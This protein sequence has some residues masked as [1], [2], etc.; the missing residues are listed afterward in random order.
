MPSSDDWIIAQPSDNCDEA[1]KQRGLVCSEQEL[2]KHNEEVDSCE[3]LKT[4]LKRLGD[5]EMQSC[6]VKNG[7]RKGAPALNTKKSIIF[8]SSIDRPLSS[9]NCKHSTRAE[10]KRRICFCHGS[11]ILL[12]LFK[13]LLK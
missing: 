7:A 9:Y 4:L 12:S 5:L 6:D 13:I 10:D 3:E 2:K 11:N 8:A 1:C